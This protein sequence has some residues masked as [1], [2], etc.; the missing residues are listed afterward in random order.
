MQ[1]LQGAARLGDDRLSLVRAPH[2]KGPHG[3]DASHQVPGLIVCP[4]VLQRS[5]GG[6]EL[7]LDARVLARAEQHL[8][9]G[10]P[11]RGPGIQRRGWQRLQP[12]KN[13]DQC[14][15]KVQGHPVALDEALGPLHVMA[16][17]SMLEGLDLEAVS[18]I[19][20]AGTEVVLVHV[21]ARDRM[22]AP[23]PQQLG[24]QV[25]V[26][27]PAPLVVQG[28]A[29]Q[30]CPLEILEG[31]LTGSRGVEQHGI[32]ERTAQP[33]EDGRPQQEG[34]HGVRLPLED[35][36]DQ[37]VEH[38]VVAAS[39][40]PM[41][42]ATSSRPCSE[43]AASCRPAIQPSVRVSRAAMSSAVRFRPITWLRKSATSAGVKRRS[44]PRTSVNWLRARNRARGSAGILTGGDDHVQ[45]RRQVL[46]QEGQRILHRPGVEDVVV[47]ENEDQIAGDG[48]DVVE[49]GRQGRFGR[50]RGLWRLEHGQYPVP[51]PG[52]HCLQGRDQ[53]GQ[54]TAGVAVAFVERQP[55]HRSPAAR[56]PFADQR[57]LAKAGGCGDQGQPVAG[58]EAVVQTL[59]E[60]RTG[61]ASQPEGWEVELGG[62][63]RRGH[64]STIETGATGSSTGR[65]PDRP[66]VRDRKQDIQVR[67]CDMGTSTHPRSCPHLS[68]IEQMVGA[69]A[70]GGTDLFVPTVWRLPMR[71]V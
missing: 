63:D 5:F 43:I 20:L 23:L 36:F 61:D 70:K 59:H 7:R 24:E 47:V 68:E 66:C 45:L 51:D 6:L 67:R 17:R 46:D 1:I 12:V 62:Q 65:E 27:I 29:E 38:K 13:G 55:R 41:K 42:P 34:L 52:R 15:T 16:S 21:L 9:I 50:W 3:G 35:F 56:D 39:E 18:L 71:V 11:K 69:A 58:G 4:S 44:A 22:L 25:V 10:H 33:I 54:E 19:P 60:S 31:L 28:D 40:R 32:A 57:G 8:G 30:V 2:Q 64:Q 49:E 53:V 26:A 48:G 37:I 14:A